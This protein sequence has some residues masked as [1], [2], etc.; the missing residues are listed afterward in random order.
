MVYGDKRNLDEDGFFRIDVFEMDDH[1]QDQV[2]DLLSNIN[3][4]NFIDQV[5]FHAF[6]HEFLAINGFDIEGVDYDQDV[7]NKV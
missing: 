7:D 1:I 4:D 3:Q 6:K 5:D 2:I